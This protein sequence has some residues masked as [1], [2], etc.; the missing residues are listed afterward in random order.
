MNTMRWKGLVIVFP[1]DNNGNGI[2]NSSCVFLIEQLFTHCEGTN[3]VGEDRG[4]RSLTINK[5]L[6]KNKN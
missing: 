1:Y 4:G 3:Q 2:L 5:S 6:S